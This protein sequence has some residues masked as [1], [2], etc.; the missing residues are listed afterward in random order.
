MVRGVGTRAQLSCMLLA[1]GRL[2]A[3]PA[4]QTSPQPDRLTSPASVQITAFFWAATGYAAT[5]L[6]SQ[7]LTEAAARSELEVLA[8]GL[9]YGSASEL[10][11]SYPG[12]EK[13][14][15]FEF[16]TSSAGF[17]VGFRLSERA[18]NR[19]Q[20]TFKLEP[21]LKAFGRHGRIDLDFMVGDLDNRAFNYRGIRQFE[22][23]DVRLRHHGAGPHHSYS[24][25]VLNPQAA[26]F[27][28]P[29]F[30]PPELPLGEDSRRT[31]PKHPAGSSILLVVLAT[32]AA[33][34]TFVVVER[35]LRRWRAGTNRRR[36]LG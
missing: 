3:Q 4:G 29:P 2:V 19:D 32:A 36:R 8:A 9:G 30:A 13:P 6:Y 34:G 21:F 18:F 11:R 24:I 26:T 14:D 22:S 15:A 31:S 10:R 23:R 16:E 28:L 33:L 20:G 7:P 5:A 27:D 1:V 17:T 25:E 12:T 35:G